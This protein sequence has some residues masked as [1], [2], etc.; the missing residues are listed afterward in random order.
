MD[1]DK[2]LFTHQG[3]L[4]FAQRQ[5]SYFSGKTLWVVNKVIDYRTQEHFSHFDNWKLIQRYFKGMKLV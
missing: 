3:Q 4:Y 2:R 5:K 1:T